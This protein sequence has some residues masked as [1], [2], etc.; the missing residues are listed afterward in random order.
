MVIG[1]RHEFGAG[2]WTAY[3][4]QQTFDMVLDEDLSSL[5]LPPELDPAVLV[6]RRR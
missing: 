4:R 2:D 3:R 6:F 5:V 1:T